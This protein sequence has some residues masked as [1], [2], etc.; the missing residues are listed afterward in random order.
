MYKEHNGNIDLIEIAKTLGVSD[1][2]VRGWKNKDKW[3]DK[4]NG[5]FQ[6][7]DK[8]NTDLVKCR[9]K[10]RNLTKAGF[11]RIPSLLKWY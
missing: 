1:G 9:V 6:K 8:K 4:L 10:Y 11:L 7:E 5:T 3:I 2:T